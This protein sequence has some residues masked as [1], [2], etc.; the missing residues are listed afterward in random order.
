MREEGRWEG[1][2]EGGGVVGGEVGG[3]R[4]NVTTTLDGNSMVSELHLAQEWRVVALSAI[5]SEGLPS[6][7]RKAA[8]LD[9]TC[10]P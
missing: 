10:T 7:T 3:G 9:A 2:G 5:C 4:E 8:C 6:V 1:G